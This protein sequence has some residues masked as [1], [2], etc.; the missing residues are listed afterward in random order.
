MSLHRLRSPACRQG[1]TR[2]TVAKEIRKILAILLRG[3]NATWGHVSRGTVLEY[4]Q[5]F[6]LFCLS[7]TS[8]YF[9]WRGLYRLL[10]GQKAQSMHTM[11]RLEGTHRDC[12]ESLL[13]V[14][15]GVGSDLWRHLARAVCLG[16]AA[17]CCFRT[18]GRCQRASTLVYARASG[19]CV[20]WNHRKVLNTATRCCCPILPHIGAHFAC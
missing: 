11:Q 20:R 12:D 1:R 4:L 17:Y 14:V 5:M 10:Q 13:I 3:A 16:G 19:R 7:S 2:I 8:S 18:E 6:V 9:D 15:C